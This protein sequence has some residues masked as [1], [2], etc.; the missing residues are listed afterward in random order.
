[1]VQLQTFSK[2]VQ[3]EIRC[4]ELTY[5][6]K[7]RRWSAKTI[8]SL[9]GDTESQQINQANIEIAATCLREN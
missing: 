8:V 5:V 6:N 4:A 2:R 1:M 3:K 7:G 9:S